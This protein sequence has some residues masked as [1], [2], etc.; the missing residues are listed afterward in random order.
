M[1]QRKKT[2][3]FL[4]LL[5]FLA[6]TLGGCVWANSDV[7]HVRISPDGRTVVANSHRKCNDD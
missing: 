4:V 2:G 5:L 3:V 6:T 7:D 1:L